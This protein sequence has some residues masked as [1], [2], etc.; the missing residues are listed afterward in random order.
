MGAFINNFFNSFFLNV[1]NLPTPELIMSEIKERL[2][3]LKHH[4]DFGERGWWNT[5]GGDRYMFTME[6]GVILQKC[7]TTFVPYCS[8]P[9]LWKEGGRHVKANTCIQILHTA[10]PTKIY[11]LIHQSSPLCPEQNRADADSRVLR[12]SLQVYRHCLLKCV[13]KE[14][15]IFT[16]LAQTKFSDKNLW[17]PFYIAG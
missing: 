13:Q 3:G 12:N 7:L 2:E 16:F 17:L 15:W 8:S 5:G 6:K 9:S 11:M 1:V 10:C 14:Y 4:L